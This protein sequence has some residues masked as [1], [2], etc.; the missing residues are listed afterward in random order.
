MTI[1]IKQEI[2][3][4]N[5]NVPFKLYA[6]SGRFSLSEMT[7]EEVLNTLEGE[8]KF[9][10]KCEPGWVRVGDTQV[11]FPIEIFEQEKLIPKK[12]AAKRVSTRKA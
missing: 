2:I 12:P 9:D 3:D 6:G 7:V 1:N 8:T 5:E 4:K 11:Y 10:I